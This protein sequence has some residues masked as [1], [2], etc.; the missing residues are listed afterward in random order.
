MPKPLGSQIK[1]LEFTNLNFGF[2]FDTTDYSYV[3]LFMS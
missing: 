3:T 1:G 2:Y